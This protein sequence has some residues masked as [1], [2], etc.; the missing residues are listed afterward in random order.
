MQDAWDSEDCRDCTEIITAQLAYE[1][2]GV[3]APHRSIVVRSCFNTITDSC[4]CDMC[5]GVENC[6]GCFGLKKKSYCIFNKQYEKEEYLKL[7]EKIIEYMRKT[8]EWGEYFP[9]SLSPF[10]YNESMAQDY[11]PLTKVEALQKGFRWYERPLRDY[12]ITLKTVDLPKNFNDIKDNIT[13]EIIECSSQ[14][15]LADKEKYQLCTT[16]FKVTPLELNLYKILNLPVPEKCF[17][18][19]RQ[20]RL[21]MR[22]PRKIWHRQCMCDKNTHNHLGRCPKEFETAY[23]PGRQE[24][25]YCE[26]CYNREIY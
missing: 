4:Y 23:T 18:C 11:F 5:F 26:D 1:A 9:S 19:R 16:A 8:K 15:S 12:Q 14:N 2:Q 25:I 24:I 7:K 17:P 20:D 3:E 6:F 21:N 10:A 22:N 13:E